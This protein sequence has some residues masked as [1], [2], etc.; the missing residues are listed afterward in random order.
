M[1]VG[2]LGRG[3][4]LWI[5]FAFVFN[6]VWE[7]S[8]PMPPSHDPDGLKGRGRMLSSSRGSTENSP[9]NP[10]PPPPLGQESPDMSSHRPVSSPLLCKVILVVHKI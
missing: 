3:D 2:G 1:G 10:P 8:T 6:A 5:F 4:P 9:P 7:K